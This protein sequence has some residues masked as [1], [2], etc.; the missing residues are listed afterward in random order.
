MTLRENENKELQRLLE[1]HL[2]QA[3]KNKEQYDFH[4]WAATLISMVR[5]IR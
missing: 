4:V 1:W 2:Q 5:E 3:N